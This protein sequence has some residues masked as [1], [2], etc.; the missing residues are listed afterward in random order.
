MITAFGDLVRCQAGFEPHELPEIFAAPVDGDEN[1]ACRRLV[2]LDAA[3]LT[4]QFVLGKIATFARP[5]GGG[6][7]V[8]I[9]PAHWEIDDPLPRLATGTYNAADWANAEAPASHRIFV[10]AAEFDAWLA[11]LQPP[12]PLTD[13]QIEEVLDPRLRAARSTAARKPKRVRR[14]DSPDRHGLGPDATTSDTPVNTAQPT[15]LTI[16][17]VLRLTRLGR[18][19]AYRLLS[20]GSFPNPIKIGRSS[21]WLKSDVDEWIAK[22]ATSRDRLEE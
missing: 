7:T 2:A 6:E 22:Q 16:K 12:G 17:E 9:P 4:T 5:L 13:S 18:S 21:R 3:L 20:A 15:L 14:T 19:T 10:D 1:D 8:E 11:K